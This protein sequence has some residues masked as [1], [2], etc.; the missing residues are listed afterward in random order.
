MDWWL[1]F[2]QC[3]PMGKGCS[4]DWDAWSLVVALIALLFA[5]LSILVTAASA[6]AVYWLA[7]KAN[8]VASAS[9]DVA[10]ATHDVAHEDRVR[11][12]RFMLIYLH[13]ELLDVHSS[14]VAWLAHTAFL[15]SSFLTLDDEDRKK[16][17]VPLLSLKFPIAEERFSRLHVLD[18]VIG[19]S[20]ARALGSVRFIQMAIGPTMRM[21]N[22][23][24]GRTQVRSLID[25]VRELD[26]DVKAVID[27]A[28][29]AIYP[30]L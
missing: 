19:H 13:P 11:E 5:W 21:K 9:H 3:W 26:G 10:S 20:F 12:A 23:E 18:P 29:K 14:V 17:L 24:M 15:E 16:S 6:A 25:V 22:D 27:A 7:R 30:D 1:G 28:Q 2:N 8:D 4:V